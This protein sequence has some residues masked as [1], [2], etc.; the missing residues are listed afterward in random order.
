MKSLIHFLLAAVCFLS[1]HVSAHAF[2]SSCGPVQSFTTDNGG[3]GPW[4]AGDAPT[5]V[6][7]GRTD[8]W[9]LKISGSSTGTANNDL[10]LSE[11][12]QSV[13]KIGFYAKSASGTALLH[14]RITD[15]ATNTTI[16]ETGNSPFSVDSSSWLPIVIEAPITGPIGVGIEVGQV[17]GGAVAVMIDDVALNPGLVDNEPSSCGPVQSFTT[18]NGGWGPWW[19]GDAPTRV[20]PGRTDNWSLKISGSSTGTANNDMS[21][22]ECSQ[23]VTKIGFYAKSASGTALLHVRITDLATNTTIWETGN[24]PFF[25]D[26]SS[27]LPIVIEAPITG[28][29]GVGIE[30]GQVGGGAVAVM[31]DDVA[32]NPGL[33]DNE[34]SSCGPVQSFT[35]DNGGWGPWWAGDA[36]T[37]VSPG[38]TDN[39]SLKISGSSTGTANNDM[40]LSECSQPVTKI[41]F[42]AKSASGNALLHV[43][44]TDLATNTTI[45]ETGSNPFSIDPFNWLPI[46]IEAPIT[47]PI[48]VGIEVGQVGGGAVAVMIDDVALNP[49][50][51]TVENQPDNVPP[52][53]RDGWTLTFSDTFSSST[54]DAGKWT[55]RTTGPTLGGPEAVGDSWNEG[56]FTSP[57]VAILG[58]SLQLTTQQQS[59]SCLGQ[60]RNW[61][62]GQ[63][64]SRSLFAQRYGRFEARVKL[65]IAKG[66]W[67]AFWLM[68]NQE[69][70]YGTCGRVWPCI[71]EI[72]IFEYVGYTNST[73]N[74]TETKAIHGTSHWG[75]AQGDHLQGTAVYNVVPSVDR[76]SVIAV[77]WDETGISYL[78]DENLY[79]K[80]PFPLSGSNLYTGAQP[81]D[82]PFYIILN[83]SAGGAWPGEPNL[84]DF[85]STMKVD[86][87]AVYSRP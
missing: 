58:G 12:S 2:A 24:S 42:Y 19:A 9:S 18:D 21:L 43:R 75:N 7:P 23:A 87:V 25:V 16:W 5:R 57:Q 54:L 78:V 73:T 61:V 45:W 15:L 77:E 47:G 6:S 70:T 41:G 8:N 65:G 62:G 81:F 3:W 27:W 63:I 56:C 51:P 82:V 74:A 28:P 14:V 85:P 67:S 86:Y 38:R 48:G 40:S 80:I 84:S 30:V 76:W 66:V 36:P 26:S 59:V 52:P 29:I 68:P 32:L 72:D 34:P 64:S 44:I 71:G 60:T 17:G 20:S 13:T 33:V 31:I 11:C 79:K 22:S 46:I 35:T 50:P 83:Q 53:A 4:W 49:G 69:N 37:R 39:W 1:L 10:S 55:I